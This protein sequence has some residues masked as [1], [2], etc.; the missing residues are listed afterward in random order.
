MEAKEAMTIGMKIAERHMKAVAEMYAAK[1]DV[2]AEEALRGTKVWLG[3]EI[4][5]AL[6]DIHN[7]HS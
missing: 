2:T 5:K 7:S 6:C 3:A 4:M 1:P